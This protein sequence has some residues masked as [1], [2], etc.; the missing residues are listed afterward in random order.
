MGLRIDDIKRWAKSASRSDLD[1]VIKGINLE[2]ESR[3]R[4]P[5]VDHT[6]RRWDTEDEMNCGFSGC[7]GCGR[8][9]PTPTFNTTGW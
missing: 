4:R 9:S 3:R 1:A 6:G 7:R 5:D 8:C 2:R